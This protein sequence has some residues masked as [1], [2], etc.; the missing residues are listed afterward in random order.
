MVRKVCL[1][2]AGMGWGGGNGLRS[3]WEAGSGG[4]SQS[5]GISHILQMCVLLFCCCLLSEMPDSHT[6]LFP[7]LVQPPT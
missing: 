5:P 2:G 6:W 3:S 7:F 4:S 1:E